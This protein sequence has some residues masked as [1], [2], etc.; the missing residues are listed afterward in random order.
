VVDNRNGSQTGV[1]KFFKKDKGFGFITSNSG[2]DVFFH[3]TSCKASS[4]EDLKPSAEV[5]FSVEN[6]KDGRVRAV[7][8]SVL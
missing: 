6:D 2:E 7:N 5:S 8:V 3:I 1:I 4:E